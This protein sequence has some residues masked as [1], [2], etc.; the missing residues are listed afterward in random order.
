[1]CVKKSKQR[2]THQSNPIA[3]AAVQ[4]LKLYFDLVSQPARALFMFLKLN[5]IPFE[6]CR[7]SI[8]DGK[9]V[10]S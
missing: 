1:M 4:P 6:P 9:Y 10:S 8:K 7:I 2:I 5:N 3:M